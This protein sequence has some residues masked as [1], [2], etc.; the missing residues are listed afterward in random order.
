MSEYHIT[1]H[2]RQG[3]ALHVSTARRATMEFFTSVFLGKPEEYP[4][5]SVEVGGK[6]W[7]GEK[8]K[9]VP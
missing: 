3:Q 1:I 6:V 7:V 9:E 2:P 5:V 4:T 8:I